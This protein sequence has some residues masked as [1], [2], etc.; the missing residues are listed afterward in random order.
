MI[1]VASDVGGCATLDFTGCVRKAVPD[2]LALSAFVPRTLDLECRGRCAPEKAIGETRWSTG[3]DARPWSIGARAFPRNSVA[4]AAAK[5]VATNCRGFKTSSYGT[6][7]EDTPSSCD[8]R[9]GSGCTGPEGRSKILKHDPETGRPTADSG[10]NITFES[11]RHDAVSAMRPAVARPIR[12]TQPALVVAAKSSNT[13]GE[14][15][16]HIG[17]DG[18][19]IQAG[20]NSP[21]GRVFEI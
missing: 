8:R 10:V 15:S 7:E 21:K 4:P 20:R 14:S 16:W 17:R 1:L 9:F 13:R 3:D 18:E 19:E 11:R 6:T 12:P 5:D 2:G